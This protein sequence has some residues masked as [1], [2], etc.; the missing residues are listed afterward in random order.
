MF[1]SLLK[2]SKTETLNIFVGQ[3]KLNDHFFIFIAIFDKDL[4]T[5]ASDFRFF[6]F[7]CASAA[8]DAAKIKK[9]FHK[10]MNFKFFEVVK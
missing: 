5:H 9:F 8:L 7:F 3:L 2:S 1:L 4:P 6:S 10:L